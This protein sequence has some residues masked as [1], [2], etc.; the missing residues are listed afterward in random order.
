M[1]RQRTTTTQRTV[2]AF[3]TG[4]GPVAA[5][6]D[7]S[8][9][10]TGR[11]ARE[12]GLRRTEFDL[13]VRL[14]RVRTDPGR[15]PGERRVARAEIERLRAGPD[16]PEA[17]RRSVHAV[18]TAEGAELLGVAKSRF[19]RLARLGLL[20]PVAFHLNRYRA[21]VWLYLADEL[22]LFGDDGK[23]AAL[24]TGRMPEGLR[25]LLDS[26]IDLRP[27]N[28]RGRHLGFLLREAEDPWARAGA[29][30]SFLDPLHVARVVR[31]PYDR[32]HLNTFRRRPPGGANPDSPGARIAADLTTA[33]D[34]DEIAW[35]RADLARLVDEARAHRPAPRPSA[36]C[37]ATSA[38]EPLASRRP[39]LAPPPARP[40]ASARPDTPAAAHRAR[41][42]GLL[43]RWRHRTAR[44]ATRP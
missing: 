8:W 23:H 27:R 25:G 11:A 5:A 4:V 18:G 29:V 43:A 40:A 33:R 30:A 14:G 34:D 42:R 21:V 32:S 2:T 22:R 3:D 15:V 20:I 9:V 7:D 19:T 13:A 16:F 12:L 38:S 37:R 1:S 44:T 6:K 26:G 36:S 41:R 28:W 35:L 39:V 10:T 24:L 17:L 31:D